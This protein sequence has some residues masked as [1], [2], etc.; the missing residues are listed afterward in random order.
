MQA[1]SQQGSKPVDP[2]DL[3]ASQQLLL[4]FKAD[5]GRTRHLLH[6]L[7]DKAAAYSDSD[8]VAYSSSFAGILLELDTAADALRCHAI[9]LVLQLQQVRE[10]TARRVLFAQAEAAVEALQRNEARQVARLLEAQQPAWQATCQRLQGLRQRM[11]TGLAWRYP[12]PEHIVWRFKGRWGQQ[13]QRP[14]WGYMGGLKQRVPVARQGVQQLP[15]L[16]SSTAGPDWA[17]AAGHGE[18]QQQQP[19][20]SGSSAGSAWSPAAAA[21]HG[22]QQQLQS[23]STS[24]PAWSPMPVAVQGVQQVV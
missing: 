3:A 18:Q 12:P 8:Y 2:D 24:R 7:Q 13:Q 11:R 6:T 17:P 20:Q 10:A 14:L 4:N 23:G 5:L 15:P 9:P 1:T 22:V 21:G 16:G 19:R